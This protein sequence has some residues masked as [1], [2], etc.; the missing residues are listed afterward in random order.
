M[1]KEDVFTQERGERE[2]YLLAETEDEILLPITKDGFEALL[3]AAASRYSLPVD[4]SMRSVLAGYVHHIENEKN[5]TTMSQI[6]RV[7]YKSVANA[8]TWSIDQDIKEKRRQAMAAAKEAEQQT[9]KTEE[10]HIVQ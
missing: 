5:T 10:M 8:L 9:E 6:S 7:L 3:S 1:T 2:Q 4:D